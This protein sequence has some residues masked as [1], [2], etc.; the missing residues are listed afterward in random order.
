MCPSGGA[1]SAGSYFH[2]QRFGLC[3]RFGSPT[4][5]FRRT[6]EE[7]KAADQKLTGIAES[8]VNEAAAEREDQEEEPRRLRIAGDRARAR[9]RAK[10]DIILFFAP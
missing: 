2:A 3:R 1:G 8:F 9:D 4:K 5:T 6:L 7:E 10:D